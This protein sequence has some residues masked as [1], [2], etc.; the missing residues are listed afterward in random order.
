MRRSLAAIT[1]AAFGLGILGAAPPVHADPSPCET[2]AAPRPFPAAAGS[3]F[4]A[5]YT[6]GASASTLTSPALDGELPDGCVLDGLGYNH[7]D[8]YLYALHDPADSAPTLLRIGR[9]DDGELAIRNIGA[10]SGQPQV[11]DIDGAGRYATFAYN[12]LTRAG[13]VQRFTGLAGANTPVRWHDSCGQLLSNLQA[14]SRLKAKDPKLPAPASLLADWAYNP[15]DEHLYGYASADA[16][17]GYLGKADPT[18]KWTV[19][20][21]PDQ[22]IRFN[23]EDGMARCAPVTAPSVPGGTERGVPGGDTTM[24]GVAFTGHDQLALFQLSAGRRW[25][26]DVAE[27]FGPGG[28]V[29]DPDGPAP[30]GLG[31]AAGNPYEP[32][33]ITVRAIVG[34]AP[35]AAPRRV[36]RFAFA[37]EDLDPD[38]FALGPGE[39]R[40][41]D[42]APGEVTLAKAREVSGWRLIS[43]GCRGGRPASSGD[44]TRLVLGPGEQIICTYAASPLAAPAPSASAKRVKRHRGS[45]T[46]AAQDAAQPAPADL[47]WSRRMIVSLPGGGNPLVAFAIFMLLALAIGGAVFA[48]FPRRRSDLPPPYRPRHRA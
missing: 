41:F 29:V 19:I 25:H 42:L 7:T 22:A 3:T 6:P 33:R 20:P 13:V 11:A 38:G 46:V 47:P 4:V 10:L 48:L 31:D 9:S 14:Q 39:S 32:A 8:G 45:E 16:P 37:S 43:T 23:P 24:A 44:P 35:G 36:Q 1:T 17:D 15:A 21:L 34:Q 5:H 26:L 18:S 27:C 30:D 12:P 2:G 40:T 28:C